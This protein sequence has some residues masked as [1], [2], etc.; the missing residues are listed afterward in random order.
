MDIN[1]AQRAGA[2]VAFAMALAVVFLHYPFEGYKRTYNYTVPSFMPCPKG[3]MK[4]LMRDMGAQEFNERIAACQDKFEVKDLPFS[5][6]QSNGALI[7][8]L[9]F[10]LR[11][12]YG[13]FSI[14]LVFAAWFFLMRSSAPVS[15]S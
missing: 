5:D 2:F 11:A 4:Q 14:L 13:V 6:W 10:P 9:A 3:D 8:W 1:F 7:A 15:K 12:I